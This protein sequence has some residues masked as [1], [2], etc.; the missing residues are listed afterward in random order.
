MPGRILA[1]PAPATL[2]IHARTPAFSRTLTTTTG[3]KAPSNL[4]TAGEP[5]AMDM[6]SKA[7]DAGLGCVRGT[8]IVLGVE[9]AAAMVVYALVHLVHLARLIH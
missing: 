3:H 8:T 5:F 4:A 1:F 2:A 9:A 7:S 6:A